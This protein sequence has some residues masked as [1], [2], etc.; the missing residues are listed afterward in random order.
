MSL[1]EFWDDSERR[2]VVTERFRTLDVATRLTQRFA[3][4]LLALREAI[5]S[6]TKVSEPALATAADALSQ[7]EER[8]LYEGHNALWLVLSD[9]DNE[10]LP[11]ERMLRLAKMYMAW[12]R[13]NELRCLPAAFEPR[14][15]DLFSRL[16]LE[17]Q[18][19]G[20]EHFLNGERGIH[21]LRRNAGAPMLIRVD[22]IAQQ[23]DGLGADVRDRALL[24]GPFALMARLQSTVALPHT[25]QSVTLIGESR[26][27][28]AALVGDLQAAW[29]GLRI[30]SP[31]IA[32]SYGEPGGLVLDP[33]TGA[34]ATLRAVERGRLET[35]HE[36]FS[37]GTQPPEG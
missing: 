2:V 17:V 22:V 26:A 19:P 37:R 31:Q 5:V 29:A 13:R 25:G 12:C 30:D 20:A 1:A 33:R 4:P 21:R 3:R 11:R 9:I 6:E 27:T 18:G 8:D 28:L 34:T 36:A 32:R 24:R 7:W 35:F 14:G 15:S 23:S 16:V 10:G